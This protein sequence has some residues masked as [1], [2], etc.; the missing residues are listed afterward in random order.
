MTRTF[1]SATADET[2]RDVVDYIDRTV[3][4]RRLRVEFVDGRIMYLDAESRRL[5]R[6][7]HPTSPK[8]ANMPTET[9]CEPADRVAIARHLGLVFGDAPI[10]RLSEVELPPSPG[11]RPTGVSA[12]ALFGPPRSNG[13]D[14]TTPTL[15]DRLHDLMEASNGKVLAAAVVTP[16]ALVAIHGSDDLLLEMEG[17]VKD[18]FGLGD[19]SGAKP[20]LALGLGDVCAVCWSE[21]YPRHILITGRPDC[22]ALVLMEGGDAA[23]SLAYVGAMMADRSV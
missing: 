16:D 6:Y 8:R 12:S 7:C 4:A 10:A 3:L 23:A 9:S 2:L 18:A 5:L 1:G 14:D 19:M 11:P 21:P 17:W 20:A 22:I 13:P 15:E